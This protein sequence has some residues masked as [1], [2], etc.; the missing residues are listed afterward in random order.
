M[1]EME[2]VHRIKE[3][4]KERSLQ[5]RLARLE[6]DQPQ[7]PGTG[8]RFINTRLDIDI[9]FDSHVVRESCIRGTGKSSTTQSL[10]LF[11]VNN[12]NNSDAH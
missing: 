4:E 7:P 9:Y 1:K 10:L 5:K 6:R 2:E 12:I 3:A 8:N 11:N